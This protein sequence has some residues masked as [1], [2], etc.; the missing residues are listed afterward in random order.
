MEPGEQVTKLDLSMGWRGVPGWFSEEE[1]V[2]LASYVIKATPGTA[3]VETGSWCG[4]SL[5]VIAEAMP[6]DIVAYAVDLH[7]EGSQAAETAQATGTGGGQTMTPAQ[8]RHTL[9]DVIAH[10][11]TLGREVHFLPYDAAEGARVYSARIDPR[12]VSVLFIDD[13]H[14]GEHLVKVFKAWEPCMADRAYLLMHDY[15]AEPLYGLQ[16]AIRPHLKGWTFDGI[17]GSIGCYTRTRR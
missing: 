6:E 12:P 1:A 14:E 3:V 9:A 8:A 2:C 15:A 4:R 10:H 13:H 17:F 5:S 11:R 16:K 7:P